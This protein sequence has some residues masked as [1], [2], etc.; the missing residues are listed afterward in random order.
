[1]FEIRWFVGP[2]G[3]L[4]RPWSVGPDQDQT[5]PTNFCGPEPDRTNEFLRTKV[6]QQ[7]VGP[8]KF[9]GQIQKFFC[10]LPINFQHFSLFL[11]GLLED[12]LLE[13]PKIE[14]TEKMRS[15]FLVCADFW[16]FFAAAV[17]QLA[18]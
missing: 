12:G 3:P 4:V 15:V 5:R 8:G 11:V 17:E 7:T 2:V 14:K 16:N 1:M 13:K 18:L 10:F 6:D 9:V